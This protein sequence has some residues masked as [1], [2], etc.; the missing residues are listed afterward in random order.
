MLDKEDE[1]RLEDFIKQS[2]KAVVNAVLG[3]VTA[4]IKQL[5]KE[6]PLINSS[7]NGM[8]TFY[9][10]KGYNKALDDLKQKIAGIS[11]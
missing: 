4:I 10:H 3:E 8:S 7:V 11:V 2:N 6:Q 1:K 5:Y 9:E